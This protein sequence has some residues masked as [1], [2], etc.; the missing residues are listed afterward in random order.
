[1]K[2]LAIVWVSIPAS[3]ENWPRPSAK[4]LTPSFALFALFSLK[5]NAFTFLFPKFLT[6][7]SVMRANKWIDNANTIII[8]KQNR[9]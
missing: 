1:V 6:C 3:E 9:K 5:E 7:A 4:A 8:R 2:H